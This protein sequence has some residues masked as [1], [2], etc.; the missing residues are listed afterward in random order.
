[1]VRQ[2]MLSYNIDDEQ[3]FF[4]KSIDIVGWKNDNPIHEDFRIDVLF[5]IWAWYL[6]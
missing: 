4:S 5:A 3:D 1:M 6:V 2:Y